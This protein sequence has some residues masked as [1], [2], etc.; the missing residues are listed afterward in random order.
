MRAFSNVPARMLT[1]F[2]SRAVSRAV[3]ILI[4]ANAETTAMT[5]IVIMICIRVKPSSPFCG[6]IVEALS[7]MIWRILWVNLSIEQE[8][9][10]VPAHRFVATVVP[11]GFGE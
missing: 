9:G 8:A 4:R 2:C 10:Q 5:V 6:R 11:A 7:V 1:E 3:P